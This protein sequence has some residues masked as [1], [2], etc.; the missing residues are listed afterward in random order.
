M[1]TYKKLTSWQRLVRML[2][3]DKRDVRQIFYYAIFSGLVGLSLPLGI[4]AIINLIQGAQIS[5]SWIVLVSIVTLGVAFGGVLQLMQIRLT[6]NIQQKIFTRSSFEFAY[7]FPKMKLSGIRGT[8]PPE[9]ANRFFDTLNVQKNL[10]K[11]LVDYPT[12]VLQ[13]VFGLMLL[14]FYHPFFIVYSFLMVLLVYLLFKFTGKRGLDS[15]IKE[16]KSKYRVAHWL[17]EIARSLVSFKLSGFTTHALNKND[18]LTKEYLKY[19]ES[20][21]DVIIL[22]GIQ[23]IVF[24]V[25]VTAGLLVIGGL[26]VLSQQMNIG[27]FVA[28]ELIILIIIGAVEKLISGLES[29]YD[30]LT[31]VEKLGEVVDKEL[32]NQS[33]ARPF[34]ENTTFTVS[35]ENVDFSVPDKA[36]PILKNINLVVNPGARILLTGAN[37]SGK[38]TLLKML[39]AMIEPSKGHMHINNTDV[40]AIDLPF[41]RSHLGHCFSEE[42][43]F[44]G[45]LRNN[46]TFGDTTV[47]DARIYEVFELLGLTSFARKQ[48]QGLETV[49]YP[50]GKQ[51]ND[52]VIRKIILAR[53]ILKQPKLL[54]LKD[55]LDQFFPDETTRIMEYLKDPARPWA[56]VV[57]SQNL[58]WRTGMDQVYT[59]VDGTLNT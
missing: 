26:L 59:V 27:Q 47:T 30:M 5:T 46:L 36:K 3:L 1:D 43:P 18:E 24:K 6:E 51:L 54:V 56:L 53:S 28:A 14:S 11:L 16:S 39:T 41:Y 44:E 25:L 48:Q 21:F 23:L 34:E 31:S 40:K 7:R 22:Q 2:R 45:T 57:A 8:Y 19:R 9:L 29:V 49:L 12:A 42:T 55:P 13:I 15:S 17:Q 20:H 32:E 38:T 4:Q 10:A 37:G 50:E 33:G 52:T 35:L 58:H